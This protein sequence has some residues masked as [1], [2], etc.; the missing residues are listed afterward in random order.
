M[1]CVEAACMVIAARRSERP[2]CDP[3]PI[4]TRSVSPVTRETQSAG[5]PSHSLISWAKLVSWPWPLDSVPMTTSTTPWGST[6][7]MARSCGAP[8]CDSI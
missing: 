4:S 2:E 8:L 7:T 6:V 3:A 5:T 1:I